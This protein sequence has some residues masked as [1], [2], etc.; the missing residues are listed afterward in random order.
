MIFVKCR[1]KLHK[2]AKAHP[3][4]DWA[5]IPSQALGSI[6]PTFWWKVQP[7]QGLMHMTQLNHARLQLFAII[8]FLVFTGIFPQIHTSDFPSNTERSK[9]L[10]P[11]NKTIPYDQ[12]ESTLSLAESQ[13]TI[14]TFV[15]CVEPPACF[16]EKVSRGGDAAHD[17]GPVFMYFCCLA[18]NRYWYLRHPHVN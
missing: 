18:T 15:I 7:K 2:T 3:V 17:S 11:T 5:L 4:N 10:I 6:E 14:P 8:L 9:L 13:Y 16:L 1:E 12:I